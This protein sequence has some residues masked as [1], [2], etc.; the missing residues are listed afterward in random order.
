MSYVAQ[1]VHDTSEWHEPRVLGNLPGFLDH[2]ASQRVG[3]KNLSVAS[4]RK[5]APH[6][7]VVAAAGLRA[8]DITRYVEF[9]VLP[10]I[11]LICESSSLRTF[12]TKD[13]IVAKLF[14]KHIKL[15]DAIEYVK[16]TR[17]AEAFRSITPRDHTDVV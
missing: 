8:A 17:Y 12:E 7:I 5:G 14:A 15:A 2:H 16:R 11:V 9:Y 4:K 1:A 13:A 10:I 6:T 3:S